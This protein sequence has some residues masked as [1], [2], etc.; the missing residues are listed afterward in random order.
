MHC[1]VKGGNLNIKGL[2]KIFVFHN[3]FDTVQNNLEHL[4]RY[5]W[6]MVCKIY[7]EYLNAMHG[8]WNGIYRS[9]D[10][11]SATQAILVWKVG[12]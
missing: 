7:D 12:L 5:G 11:Q 6:L 3:K 1:F 2:A 4:Y 8:K 9:E 10:Y